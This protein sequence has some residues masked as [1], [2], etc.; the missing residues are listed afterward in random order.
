MSLYPLAKFFLF[1]LSPE[2]A[3]ALSL[4]L[5][6]IA[7][8]LALSRLLFG[9][10]VQAPVTVMG[11]EFPN[12]VGLAA[13]MD[14]DADHVDAFADCGFGF[15]EV[16]TVTPRAQPGNPKPR[17]FR[18]I[19]DNAIINR[20]GFNNKG[21][22]HLVERVR[23]SRRNC[24]I[25]INIGKNRDTPLERAVDDYVAAFEKVYALADYVAI[26]ISSPNTPG[27]RDLQHGEE[28]DRLLS[29]LKQQQRRLSDT[30]GKYIPLVVKIAPDLSD[31]EVRE[32]A[33]T[34]LKQRID[35]VIATNTTND[36]PKL[37]CNAL[38]REQGGLSGLPLR[39]KSDHVLKL[40]C[41]SLNGQIPVMAVGGI[42]T[43]EDARRK[44]ELG[45]TLVQVY[46]GFIYKGPALISDIARELSN[47]QK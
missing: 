13:G 12:A 10:R 3:H 20:M 31:D 5:L 45:A 36:R 39:D 25:G 37:N 9:K 16:G 24:I 14:K 23:T 4:K 29:T 15:V 18:L 34:L 11:I 26:N 47:R 41:D 8:T 1:R 30:H 33:Q 42:M 32:F 40:L 21:V 6:D 35:G 19:K 46:T 22:D 44:I 7:Y 27:L 28:L 17:L 43:V 38:A 2:N